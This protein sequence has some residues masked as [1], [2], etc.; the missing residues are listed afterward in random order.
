[1]S[2][3]TKGT[4]I[5]L[6]A[7]AIWSTTGIFIGYLVTE[8]QMP[9]LL[10]AFWRNLLVCVALI[11]ALYLVRPSLLRISRGLLGF[12]AAYGLLLAIFNSI[13]TLSVQANGASVATVLA[14]SST[15]FTAVLAWWVFREQLGV[16]KIAAVALSM[17]GCVLVANAYSP[18]AWI[19][20]PLGVVTGLLSGLLFAGYN[21]MGKEAAGRG[22]NPWTSLLY[23]FA[24]GTL[25][26]FLFNLFAQ[27]PGTAGSLPAIIPGLPLGG[28]LV[29]ITLSFIPTIFGFG[30]YN[31]S[32]GYLPASTASL[33][34]A[35]EPAMTAVEAYIFL[36]ERMTLVQVIGGL[37]I[38]F[39]VVLVQ[40]EKA[41]Q[42]RPETALP[43]A[44]T[45][46]ASTAGTQ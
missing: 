1:M 46:S 26:T 22:V 24:F 14:Y 10:L 44:A 5:A 4:I 7:T 21:L 30:L 18:D 3:R 29:L 39:A 32:L 27:L 45:G 15:A 2:L 38:I 43:A 16:R 31:T 11:P 8:Y 17:F 28:W 37:I 9:P 33:I 20:N 42:G 41:E 25:F 35:L 6:V 12:Y 13:W 34:I 23:A 36:D 19:L 40:V